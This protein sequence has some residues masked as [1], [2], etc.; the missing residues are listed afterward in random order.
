M[1]MDEE[2]VGEEEATNEITAEV[3]EEM[4]K[5]TKGGKKK[6]VSVESVLREIEKVG[7]RQALEAKCAAID[8]EIAK[9]EQKM[10]MIDENEDM[11]ELVDKKL[12]KEMKKEIK[13]LEKQKAKYEKAL[14]KAKK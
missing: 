10:S 14:E 7:S 3:E 13:V 9:R 12:M 6:K 8:E 4:E 2:F 5:E 11:A 1:P